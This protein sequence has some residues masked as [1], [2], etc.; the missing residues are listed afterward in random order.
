[1]IRAASIAVML[2]LLALPVG[3]WWFVQRPIP[4][5]DA[6]VY[7]PDV[8]EP[9]LIRFDG[10]AVA[11]IEAR[12]EAD[13]YLAQGYVTAR[14]RM[15]QMDILRRIAH[16]KLSQ[17]FGPSLIPQDK[18][19]RT[20]GFSRAAQTELSYLS[21]AARDSLESYCQGVNF[22]LMSAADW[23]PL[24]FRL[25]GYRPEPWKPLDTLAVM[26]Y[27]EYLESES[28][29]LDELRQRVLDKAGA[30]VISRL[31]S[32][33]WPQSP[34]IGARPS[35]GA[36]TEP[37]LMASLAS[38]TDVPL[39]T[40][41]APCRGSNA[42]A[43]D[44]KRSASG[45]CLIAGDKHDAFSAPDL[46]YLVSLERPG[47]HVAGATIPGVPGV[48]VGRNDNIAWT[49]ASL[50]ADVQDLFVEEFSERFPGQYRTTD[51]WQDASEITEAIP[52]RFAKDLLHKVSVTRHGPLL[53]RTERTGVALSWTGSQS[54]RST[55][56]AYFNL[57]RAS[58]WS[59]FVSALSEHPGP[60]Q[61]FVYADR[62]GNIGFQG[63]GDVPV[64]AGD[65]QGTTVT[66]GWLKDGQWTAKISF[67]ELP[68]ALSPQRGYVVACNQ[69][70]AGPDYTHWLGHQWGCPYR[71]YRAAGCLADIEAARKR[72][73]LPDMN[74][75]QSDQTAY[76]SDLVKREIRE[77]IV[78]TGLVDRIQLTA[79]DLLNHWDGH[80]AANSPAASIY[81]SFLRTVTRRLAES[82]LGPELTREYM[83]RWPMW[84]L[85]TESCL[86]SKPADWLPSEERTYQTFILT[87]FS[88]ALKNLRLATRS[89]DPASWQWGSIHRATFKH[90]IDRGVPWLSSLF[91]VGAVA[92]GGDKD[93]L[94]A[95]DAT[96]AEDQGKFPS[97]SGPCLRMLAD[98]SD[99]EKFYQSICLGQSGHLFSPFRQDQLKP[100]LRAD[101]MPV[102]WSDVQLNR[103]SQHR[104]VLTNTPPQ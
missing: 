46:W 41:D 32:D 74:D 88:Q 36:C 31:F 63:A 78:R 61:A 82:K 15:F 101:P 6:L 21:G 77:S 8:A 1:M 12:R 94:N 2:L 48:L 44:G 42:W 10:R 37:K 91:D 19:V 33:Q 66:R 104:L 17:V 14:D 22:Y 80:L 35:T 84:P 85:F 25:L 3:A 100:W 57:N 76:L 75:L 38:L 16:G 79:I 62:F 99:N 95:C 72:S 50:K 40:A 4:A 28:W 54:D 90:A 67:S 11:Y 47:L 60:P 7:A 52:V 86:R 65:G 49:S 45:G 73:G 34:L 13:L 70:A 81:E 55:L 51:G 18:L 29:K 53:V 64:R 71:A 89:E 87:T 56:S 20:I 30:T 98:M 9:V 96:L 26:K 5:L 83:N 69:K 23:L 68:Q 24:E 58:S 103:Q 97:A 93:A 43:L 102:A 59:E 27:L 92:V 39:S